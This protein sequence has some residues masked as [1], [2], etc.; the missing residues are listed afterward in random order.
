[1]TVWC[2]TGG[3]LEGWRLRPAGCFLSFLELTPAETS[4]FKVTLESPEGCLGWL[5]R[6]RREITWKW[7][8]CKWS[9]GQ[10]SLP[11]TFYWLEP[12]H[13]ANLTTGKAGNYRGA[14]ETCADC[15]ALPLWASALPPQPSVIIITLF[16][17][18][19]AIILQ[20]WNIVFWLCL[21]SIFPLT[22][23]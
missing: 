2:T 16:S 15:H 8:L 19:S 13:M 9:V 17:N 7:P 12:S 4:V 22:F 18:Y 20:E 11:P 6:T 5:L 10:R 3:F 1:M 14:R 21:P 23:P